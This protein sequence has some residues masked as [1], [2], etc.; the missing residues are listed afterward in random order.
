M[1]KPAD[2]QTVAMLGHDT[3]FKSLDYNS[4][5]IRNMYD[6]ILAVKDTYVVSNDCI[7]VLIP[8]H[9]CSQR[10]P[11]TEIAPAEI[12]GIILPRD[13][14]ENQGPAPYPR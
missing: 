3:A 6:A 8:V 2:D 1:I 9:Q 10:T 7:A 4:S 13:M 11:R 14:R 5:K 12:G